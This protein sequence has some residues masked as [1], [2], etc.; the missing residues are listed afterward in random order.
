MPGK[1]ERL[2]KLNTLGCGDSGC[3]FGRP[4]GMATNGGCRCFTEP[5]SGRDEREARI[6]YRTAI[7]VAR[8]LEQ[9]LGEAVGLL[10]RTQLLL[11][12]IRDNAKSDQFQPMYEIEQLSN[13]IFEVL[14]KWQP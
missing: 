3:I 1:P 10:T 13:D 8:E 14:R 9:H 7:H 4:G 5:K 2:P 6:R 11:E 12:V